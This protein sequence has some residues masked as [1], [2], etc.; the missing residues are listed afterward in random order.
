MW[1][2]M[3]S[4]WFMNIDILLIQKNKVNLLVI[5]NIVM[6]NTTAKILTYLFDCLYILV[7]I[8]AYLLACLLACLLAIL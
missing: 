6:H 5:I 3:Y 1:I 8:L 7:Y 4:K 2:D